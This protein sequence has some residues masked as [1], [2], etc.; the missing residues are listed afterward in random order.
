MQSSY[1]SPLI[2]PP[3]DQSPSNSR[4]R[5]IY[6]RRRRNQIVLIIPLQN[7]DALAWEQAVKR[8][9]AEVKV[10]IDDLKRSQQ[11]AQITQSQYFQDLKAEISELRSFQLHEQ[12]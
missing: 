3:S 1:S 9:L 8:Q 11:V 2:Q 6:R 10:E 5:K 12:K 4:I 7:K